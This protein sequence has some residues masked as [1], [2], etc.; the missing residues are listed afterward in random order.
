VPS[1]VDTQRNNVDA[2]SRSYDAALQMFNA[3]GLA[4]FQAEKA[5]LSA[6]AHGL[7]GPTWFSSILATALSKIGSFLALIIDQVT[8]AK[9]GGQQGL[10]DLLASTLSDALLV[11]I[12]SDDIPIGSGAEGQAAVN[13]ALGKKFVDTLKTFFG[14][15][16]EVSPDTAEKGAAA[17]VGLAMQM[18]A[19]TGF[20]ATVGGAV[21]FLHFDELKETGEML[22]K[23][24]GI[25]RLTRQALLP[26]IHHAVTRPLERKYAAQFQQ[27]L[28]G[29]A[30]LATAL[31]AGRMSKERARQFMHEH[32]LSDEMADELIE[33][34]TPRLHPEETE[35][36]QAL[37]KSPQGDNFH[38]IVSD[39]TPAEVAAA[40]LAVLTYRRKGSVRG[41]ILS[42]VLSQISDGFLSPGDLDPV[43]SR[44]GVPADEVELWRILAGYSGERTR[45]RLSHGD[46]LFLYEAAQ[47]TLDDVREWAK[48][49]GYSDDDTDRLLLVFT[50]RSAGAHAGKA[51]GA[52]AKA[53]HAHNEHVAYVTDNIRG[54]FGRPPSKAELDF[55]VNALDQGDRTKQDFRTEIKALDTAGSAIP[56]Q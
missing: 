55:W 7:M 42:T 6:T 13:A 4:G 1:E 10:H 21:P 27:D 45:K 5:A 9:K 53:A 37:D 46:M 40:R 12:K 38:Q 29:A 3:K 52:A 39:G 25:G 35:L 47:V 8:Q 18:S 51:G 34:H 36:L 23:S 41:H 44:L 19:N 2:A 11:E 48:A 16:G 22:E 43:L 24:L 50:L 56:P 31:L 54:L 32:G 26:L 28:L 14:A 20:L 15:N 33:Q 17:L 49:E 30:Q